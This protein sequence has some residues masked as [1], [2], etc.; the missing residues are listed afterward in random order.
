MNQNADAADEALHRGTEEQ[1]LSLKY[2]SKDSVSELVGL[3][4]W[5]R[6][7]SVDAFI[8][9]LSGRKSQREFQVMLPVAGLAVFLRGPR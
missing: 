2:L 8:L 9:L 6:T 4:Q 1:P 3:D 7:S 5:G